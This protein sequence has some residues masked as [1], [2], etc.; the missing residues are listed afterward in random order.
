MVASSSGGAAQLATG[1]G[2]PALRCPSSHGRA[3]RGAH[4]AEFINC[5]MPESCPCRSIVDQLG[6][7]LHLRRK[8][9][10]AFIPQSTIGAV[11]WSLADSWISAAAGQFLQ[12]DAA[13]N[14]H[15]TLQLCSIVFSVRHLYRVRHPHERCERRKIGSGC[16]Q[17][18]RSHQA[19]CA[20]PGLFVRG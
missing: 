11:N 19:Q 1:V 10:T 9:R 13:L 16:F 5:T 14:S 20:P 4:D 8:C 7:H 3:V 12:G 6:G 2:G 15:W 18:W 17:A